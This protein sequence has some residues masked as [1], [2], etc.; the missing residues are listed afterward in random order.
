MR[1]K[2]GI[3][4]II[5]LLT[6]LMVAGLAV[7]ALFLSNMNLR[8][9]ENKRANTISNYAARGGLDMTLVALAR[10]W[11]ERVAAYGASADMPPASD[12]PPLLASLPG[13]GTEFTLLGYTVDATDNTKAIVRIAGSTPG[14]GQFVSEALVRGTLELTEDTG[15]G[16]G[17]GDGLISTA[18]INCTSGVTIATNI[19]AGG[20]VKCTGRAELQPGYT[21]QTSAEGRNACR[22]GRTRCDTGADPPYVAEP[23]FVDLYADVVADSLTN[24]GV[25]MSVTGACDPA[26]AGYIDV[27]DMTSSEAVFIRTEEYLLSAGTASVPLTG[28]E[29]IDTTLSHWSH[30]IYDTDGTT[31]IDEMWLAYVYDTV[32]FYYIDGTSS[33]VIGGGYCL[34]PNVRVVIDGTVS[35]TVIAGDESTS[36]IFRDTA[37][38]QPDTTGGATYDEMGITVVAGD[39]QFEKGATVPTFTGENTII[40]KN[41]LVV[42]GGVAPNPLDCGTDCIGSAILFVS[43]YDIRINGNGGLPIY[44]SFWA[45]NTFTVNGS[46]TY[47]AGNVWAYGK[48]IPGDCS[49]PGASCSGIKINGSDT[50]IAALDNYGNPFEPP[51]PTTYASNGLRILTRR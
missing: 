15:G 2:R 35:N 36:V 51:G 5:A 19:H 46:S 28:T 34:A 12:V 45:G 31:V 13:Y 47:F 14:G 24:Y 1:S 16:G 26:S 29:Y 11:G 27:A 44:A 23:I 20:T 25:D 7:G 17:G 40:S 39:I 22:I 6:L 38:M 48:D 3:G 21:A 37:V 30:N 10:E 49:S 9:S 33:P 42:P 50:V 41:D 43:E 32:Y 8:L 4:T 18:G